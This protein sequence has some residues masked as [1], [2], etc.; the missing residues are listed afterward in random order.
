MKSRKALRNIVAI[1]IFGVLLCSF[2]ILI[3]GSKYLPNQPCRPILFEDGLELR[4]TFEPD[5][6][7]TLDP[8]DS[9]VLFFDQALNPI[10]ESESLSLDDDRGIW[11]I[12]QVKN[13][14]LIYSCRG[15]DTF[16]TNVKGCI[17]IYTQDKQNVIESV[18]YQSAEEVMSCRTTPLP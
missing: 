8:I 9:I 14:G 4:E 15:K 13:D 16:G 7:L 3:A 5:F 18:L 10:S 2:G 11:I 6:H 17:Y 1:S 12:N